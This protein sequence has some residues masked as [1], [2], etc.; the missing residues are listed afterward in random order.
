MTPPPAGPM[1]RRLNVVLLIVSIVVL[2]LVVVSGVRSQLYIR[3]QAGVNEVLIQR[4]RILTEF[5]DRERAAERH[6][7]DALDAVLLDPSLLKS[8]DERTPADRQR[9]ARLFADYLNTARTLQTERAAADKA[10]ADNPVP[11]P[12]SSVCG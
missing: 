5:G 4:S 1:T 7:G 9:V 10:R 3:C 12:P 2:V 6:R 11:P 8:A